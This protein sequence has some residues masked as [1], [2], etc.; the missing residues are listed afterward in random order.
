MK[1][2]DD[3]LVVGDTWDWT[4]AVDNYPASD[5]WTLKY[6]VIPRVAGSNFTL[7]AATAADG[8]SY[9][10]T[11]APAETAARTAGDYSWKAWVEKVGARVSVAEGL[12][13]LEPDPAIATAL[14]GRSYARK[15]LDSIEG[16]LL[17]FNIG[18]KSY[19]I[20]SRSMTKADIPEIL[21]MR[22]RFK[23]EVENEV[24]IDKM[25]DGLSNPRT[26]GVRLN[27]V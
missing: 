9:R 25:T 18:V 13:T 26:F 21:T 27:R 10:M 8:V 17:A 22:D 7:T 24:A 14:D 4:T 15:M 20:G 12:V 2:M 6:R 11:A 19:Q 3:S 1:L 5:G 23:A 16:A